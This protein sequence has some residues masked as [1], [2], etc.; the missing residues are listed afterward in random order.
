MEPGAWEQ[1][2][3]GGKEVPQT[4]KNEEEI[5]RF[6]VSFPAPAAQRRQPARTRASQRH[7]AGG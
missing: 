5:E 3:D 1:S 2:D 6:T 4:G 7:P